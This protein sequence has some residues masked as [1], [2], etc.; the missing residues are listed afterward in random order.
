MIFF[1][2]CEIDYVEKEYIFHKVIKITIITIHNIVIILYTHITNVKLC[3][4][5]WLLLP[6]AETAVSILMLFVL[7]IANTLD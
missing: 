6:Q 5:V 2:K 4:Y 1:S 7:H 3:E